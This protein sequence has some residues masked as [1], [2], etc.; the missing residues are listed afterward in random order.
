[1]GRERAA[2]YRVFSIHGRFVGTTPAL[3]HI[4][5]GVADGA[6]APLTSGGR[7]SIKG[8][9]RPNRRMAFTAGTGRDLSRRGSAV[10]IV[11]PALSRNDE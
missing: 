3:V 10:L 7:K 1:M 11:I 8:G 2:R 6:V 5:A 9:E 4:P